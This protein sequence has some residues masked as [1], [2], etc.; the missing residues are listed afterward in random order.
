MMFRYCHYLNSKILHVTDLAN[1]SRLHF[2][3]DK[4]LVLQPGQSHTVTLSIT[5]PSGREKTQFFLVF[6]NNFTQFET[7]SL[8]TYLQEPRIRI[9]SP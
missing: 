2:A 7:Y 1:K 9:Q 6:A 5:F 8:T 3:H 4:P